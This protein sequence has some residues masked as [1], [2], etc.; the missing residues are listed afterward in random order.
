MAWTYPTRDHSSHFFNPIAVNG[1]MYVVAR[2]SSLV[3]LKAKSGKEIGFM[4]TSSAS[5]AA[6]STSGRARIMQI[7]V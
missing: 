6:A 4:K 2:G 3:A 7:D 1:T 5:Q